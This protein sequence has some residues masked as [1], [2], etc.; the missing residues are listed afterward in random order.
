M[1]CKITEKNSLGKDE[2]Y[3]E[4]FKCFNSKCDN[5]TIRVT[6]NYCSRCGCFLTFSK[7]LQK[8]RSDIEKR[9]K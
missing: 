5:E 7:S 8:I 1:E 3:T 6:D 2:I 9:R 4:F